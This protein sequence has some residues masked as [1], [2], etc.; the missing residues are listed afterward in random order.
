MDM[1]YIKLFES[2]LNEDDKQIEEYDNLEK[3]K[4]EA[5]SKGLKVNTVARSK[6][7]TYYQAVYDG[8]IYGHFNDFKEGNQEKKL[9][10]GQLIKGDT[11]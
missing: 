11:W 5:K 7:N 1:K 8:T 2:F 3:W 9:P 4:N 10:S 6:F